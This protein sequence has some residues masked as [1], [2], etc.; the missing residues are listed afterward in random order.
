LGTTTL[1]DLFRHIDVRVVTLTEVEAFFHRLDL[2]TATVVP[3]Q[4]LSSLRDLVGNQARLRGS[5]RAPALRQRLADKFAA[6]LFEPRDWGC[7]HIVT[8]FND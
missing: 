4:L 2:G 7:L 3:Q 1:F 5:F 8:W 6:D